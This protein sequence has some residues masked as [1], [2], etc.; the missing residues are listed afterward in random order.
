MFEL[1]QNLAELLTEVSE[2]F[3]DDERHMAFSKLR[4]ARNLVDE[5]IDRAA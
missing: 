3:E 4:D 1:L 5:M 2:L